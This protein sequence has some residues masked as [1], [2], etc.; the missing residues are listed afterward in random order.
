MYGI[1]SEVNEVK[2]AANRSRY[3]VGC[4]DRFPWLNAH[5]D[6]DPQQDPADLVVF[7]ASDSG[8][9]RDALHEQVNVMIGRESSASRVD[10][11]G[12]VGDRDP[13]DEMLE[14]A[15]VQLMKYVRCNQLKDVCVR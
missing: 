10:F 8:K 13:L 12:S 2:E 3:F 6:H 5:L 15:L 4:R 9:R 14:N 7:H 11:R 1:S